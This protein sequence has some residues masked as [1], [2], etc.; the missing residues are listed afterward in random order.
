MGISWKDFCPATLT[1]VWAELG[2]PAREADL[3]QELTTVEAIAPLGLK[4]QTRVWILEHGAE[5]LKRGCATS[6]GGRGRASATAGR[7][8]GRGVRTRASLPALGAPADAPHWLSPQGSQ[9]QGL[10]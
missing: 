2:E 7:Q 4:G 9:R 8:G 5:E 6:T 3:P 1:K 10:S